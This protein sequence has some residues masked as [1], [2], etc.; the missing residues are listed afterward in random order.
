[1]DERVNCK[2]HCNNER[3]Y[4]LH[5]FFFQ[6]FSFLLQAFPFCFTILGASMLWIMTAVGSLE[7]DSICG[8]QS[9]NGF[10]TMME[11]KAFTLTFVPLK[12]LVGS[13]VSKSRGIDDNRH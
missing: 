7:D 11:G 1:M 8:N 12:F 2:D 13:F 5:A 4:F 3:F 6:S 9:I 10:T